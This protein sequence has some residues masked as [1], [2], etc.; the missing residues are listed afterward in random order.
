MLNISEKDWEEADRDC[1]HDNLPGISFLFS[2]RE[3]G[4]HGCIR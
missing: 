2:L 4:P 3:N 1:L